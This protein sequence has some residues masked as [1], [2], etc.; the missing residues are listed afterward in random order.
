MG[1]FLP[2]VFGVDPDEPTHHRKGKRS[3]TNPSHSAPF[4][5]LASHV[6][7]FAK[8]DASHPPALF[9]LHATGRECAG[10]GWA[11]LAQPPQHSG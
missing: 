4:H 11:A 7:G 8:S 1:G 2:Y 9:P 3:Q 10:E 6:A 5:V